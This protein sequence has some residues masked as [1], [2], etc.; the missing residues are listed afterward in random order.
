MKHIKEFNS[1]KP[2]VLSEEPNIW[3]QARIKDSFFGKYTEIADG[4][5]VMHSTIDDFSYAMEHCSIIYTDVGKFCNIA[6]S[7]RINPGFHPMERPTLHHFTYRSKMYEFRDDDDEEFF[8]WREVQEVHIGHDVWIGHGSVIMPGVT[9]GNGAVI[10]SL[11]VVTKDV[12]PYEIV[13]GA[14]ARR[15]R[16]RFNKRIVAI[17][18]NI[19][20]WDWPHHLIKNRFEDFKDL[21][22][23]IRKYGK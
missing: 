12:A 20:W 17:L 10:G 3:P 18:E 22:T 1:R 5:S 14:P 8:H 4:T 9:I 2:R 6:S 23:F 13:A 19:A 7:V 21:R 16:L 15:L 11:S